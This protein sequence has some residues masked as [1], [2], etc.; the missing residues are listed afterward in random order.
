MSEPTT[1]HKDR[2][3][4]VVAQYLL[5]A[6]VAAV[7]MFWRLGAQAMD[8]HECKLALAARTMADPHPDPW[9]VEGI[10]TIGKGSAS[11]AVAYGVPPFTKFNHWV[12][13]VENGRP[14]LVKT[15]LPYWCVA[16]MAR[17]C[18]A[19]GLPGGG[20][21]SWVARLPAAISAVLAVMV[22]LA[23]GRRLLTPRAALLGA[24]MLAVCVGVQFWGRDAR[25]EMMLCLLISVSMSCFYMGLEASTRLRRAAWMAAFWLAMGLANLTKQ[26]MPE[27]LAWPLL[28]YLLWRQT[29][30]RQEDEPSLRLLRG[31]LIASGVGLGVYLLLSALL[32]LHW[33]RGVKWLDDDGGAAISLA[34]FLGG[35]MLWYFL[36]SRGWRQ[37]VPLLPTALPGMVVM[38]AM[39]GCW[40][41]YMRH[42]FPNMADLVLAE[43]VADRAAGTGRF[44][45]SDSVLVY[46]KSLLILPLPWLAFLPGGF[47]VALMKRF[48]Q[49]RRG[50]VYLFLWAVGLILLFSAAAGKREHYLLPAM[51][52]LCLLMG[53]VAEDV[54]FTHRWIQPA[55]ARLLGAAHGL[56]AIG[57]VLAMGVILLVSI[58][59][60]KWTHALVVASL[61]ATPAV[62]A[63]LWAWRGRLRPVVGLIAASMVIAYVGFYSRLELWDDLTP[64]KEFATKAARIVPPGAPL[65][66]WDDPMSKTVYYFGQTVPGV[67]WQFQRLQP[68]LT[69][70]QLHQAFGQ[71]LKDNPGR[72]PWLVGYSFQSDELGQL[73]Y[74]HRFSQQLPE[75][76]K[77]Q[78]GNKG[79][80]IVVSLMLVLYEYTGQPVATANEDANKPPASIPATRP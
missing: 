72:A 40:L 56:A 48:A 45:A 20:V 65:G 4:R 67:W 36:R 55:L 28:A 3:G 34:V 27:L 44:A 73:G 41:L 74:R 52:A 39:F 57:G 25:P 19:A 24:L 76:K 47:A 5:V 14:R 22:A 29:A 18:Q 11:R 12:V 60:A 62:L 43:E 53:F 58:E 78:K 51:P 13:P 37:I 71:W 33:W 31:F 6:V 32:V 70:P 10:I 68:T 75:R 21:N 35:P 30:K 16:A 63:G 38:F 69:K 80:T 46:L 50:L 54:F 17:L 9:M 2:P 61:A 7:I 66:S 59:R 26:F 15:P 49:H 23:L 79:G 1:A 42:L 64:V 8:D 77:A